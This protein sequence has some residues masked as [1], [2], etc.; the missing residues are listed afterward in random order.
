MVYF[1]T[2]SSCSTQESDEGGHTTNNWLQTPGRLASYI[3]FRQTSHAILVVPSANNVA[4]TANLSSAENREG[5]DSD[6]NS[7]DYGS[8]GI[9]ITVPKQ[10]NFDSSDSEQTKKKKNQK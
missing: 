4:S 6:N 5:S 7:M 1:Q 8:Q 3:S 2:N 10:L 9:Q